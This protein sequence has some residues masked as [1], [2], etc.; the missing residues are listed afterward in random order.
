M[1]RMEQPMKHRIPIISESSSLP[2]T[3]PL[4]ISSTFRTPRTAKA[5]LRS[6]RAPYTSLQQRATLCSFMASR[7]TEIIRPI[8]RFFRKVIRLQIP[9]MMPP[10]SPVSSV[11]KLGSTLVVSMFRASL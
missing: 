4:K 3:K 11:W 8:S 6:G 7:Y 10:V 2:R 5:A 1:F 9:V